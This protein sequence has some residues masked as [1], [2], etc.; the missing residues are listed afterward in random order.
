MPGS[1]LPTDGYASN[2]IMYASKPVFRIPRTSNCLYGPNDILRHHRQDSGAVIFLLAYYAAGISGGHVNPA[3][4]F[5]LLL[6][7]NFF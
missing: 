5:G 2:H 3:I 1:L 6:A 4:T 7:R